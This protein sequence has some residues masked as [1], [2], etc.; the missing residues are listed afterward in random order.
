MAGGADWKKDP[1]SY[2]LEICTLV[3]N[4]EQVYDIRHLMLEC[5]IYESITNNFLVGEI[6]IADA[7]GFLEN[8]KIFGQESLYIKFKQPFGK[9]DKPSEEDT[10]DQIF[11]IY[12][13]SGIHRIGQN[14][15]VYKLHFC[16]PELI[17]AKRIRISEARRGSM[18][19]IA[20]R[21]ARDYLGIKVLKGPFRKLE[22]FF[23]FKI[24]G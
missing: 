20:G 4:E 1:L 9:G 23:E 21:L 24:E 11:R 2:E 19:K 12:K 5:N 22:P 14:T 8:A 16:A 7:I 3:N 13:V 15:S 6:A 17:Q 18:S 10:I